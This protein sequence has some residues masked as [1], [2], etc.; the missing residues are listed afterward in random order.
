MYVSILPCSFYSKSF[1]RES[2]EPLAI[3]Q[4][5]WIPNAVLQITSFSTEV[6]YATSDTRYTNDLILP[7]TRTLVEQVIAE[8]ILP[9]PLP[10]SSSTSKGGEID[11]IAWTDRLLNTMKYLEERSINVLLTLTGLRQM[12]VS[13]PMISY[14]ALTTPS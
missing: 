11:E 3:Q 7:Q 1:L 5:S 6:R 4:F 9:L 12:Y 13:V 14:S 8:Y 10:P 2:N